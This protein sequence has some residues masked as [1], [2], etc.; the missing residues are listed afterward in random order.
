[1]IPQSLYITPATLQKLTQCKEKIAS[2]PNWM[3][4]VKLSFLYELVP[5][6]DSTKRIS[7]AFYKLYEL[8]YLYRH[9]LINTTQ[10][11]LRV[12]CLCEAPG[13]FAE[14]I[15]NIRQ[16]KKTS[17]EVQSLLNS[18]IQFS[19][20]IPKNIITFGP[21]MNGD[22][23]DFKT[24]MDIILKA[25]KKGKYNFMTADGG[26][27]S[28]N[29]YQHQEQINTKLIFCQIFVILYSLIKGGSCIIKV[30]DTF[31]LPMIQTL[32]ILQQSFDTVDIKKPS[33]SRPCNSEKYIVCLGYKGVQY[34]I[35]PKIHTFINN[36][37]YILSLGTN[38]DPSFTEHITR[39]NDYFASIQIHHL[40]ETAKLSNVYNNHTIVNKQREKQY[41]HSKKLLQSLKI[42]NHQN[43]A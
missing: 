18:D 37:K 32:W 15:M 3:K 23:T 41:T 33:L 4:Y 24:Q 29:D 43:S 38:V 30:Y 17:I 35:L 42:R 14:A 7:R 12:F 26:I 28:S 5:T 20:R 11:P 19:K 36:K 27:D 2:Y 34:P 8:Q 1:M 22:I 39:Q 10:E 40:Q 31:T 6:I 16:G 21:N 13:G 9:K 25:N